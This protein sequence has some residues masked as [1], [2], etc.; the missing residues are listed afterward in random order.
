MR[1]LLDWVFLRIARSY[2]REEAHYAFMAIVLWRLWMLSVCPN[3]GQHNVSLIVR[4]IYVWRWAVV[5]VDRGNVSHLEPFKLVVG[6]SRLLRSSESIEVI[7]ALTASSV[8]HALV[9]YDEHSVS[10]NRMSI[11]VQEVSLASALGTVL[12]RDEVASK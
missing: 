2:W 6:E 12:T 5:A 7:H 4:R 11:V 3:V 8:C 9:L 1:L 10:E